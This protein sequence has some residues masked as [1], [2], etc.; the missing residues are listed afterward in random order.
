MARFIPDLRSFSSKL[1]E[2]ATN[3]AALTFHEPWLYH[4]VAP[5][6]VMASCRKST[7]VAAVVKA[8]F[9]V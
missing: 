5:I 6:E 8:P 7:G 4:K 1:T 2:A 9:I 3:L